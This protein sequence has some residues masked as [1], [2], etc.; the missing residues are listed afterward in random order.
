M[1]FLCCHMLGAAINQ[2]RH[3]AT[4]PGQHMFVAGVIAIQPVSG[5]VRVQ[6]AIACAG[7]GCRRRLFLGDQWLDQRRA[8][9]QQYAVAVTPTAAVFS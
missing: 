7:I 9:L 5:I 3:I 6:L 2:R 4:G 1:A 8:V